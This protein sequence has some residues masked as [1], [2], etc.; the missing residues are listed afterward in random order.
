M[1]CLYFGRRQVGA[2]LV[3]LKGG[4]QHPQRA[5]S[6][7]L[8]NGHPGHQAAVAVDW[9]RQLR[10]VCR[11]PATVMAY[12]GQATQC[13]Q[14]HIA[15]R[16]EQGA[17]G[18]GG[19]HHHQGCLCQQ[20]AVAVAQIPLPVHTLQAR[21]LGLPLPVNVGMAQQCLY[22]GHR[23]DPGRAA[24]PQCR[25]LIRQARAAALL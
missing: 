2:R 16:G 23:T 8:K 4:T 3:A 24:M 5:V 12:A 20:F 13:L 11:L 17:A 22:Q 18:I 10:G 21:Y 19:S 9:K 14:R 25:G 15:Q 7:A 6:V 1:Q